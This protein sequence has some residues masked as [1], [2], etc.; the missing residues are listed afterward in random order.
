[1][2]ANHWPNTSSPCGNFHTQRSRNASP[3]LSAFGN[4]HVCRALLRVQEEYGD[5]SLSRPTLEPDL[6]ALQIGRSVHEHESILGLLFDGNKC[7]TT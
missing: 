2:C 3:L 4:W 1:M 7:D 5:R 6:L